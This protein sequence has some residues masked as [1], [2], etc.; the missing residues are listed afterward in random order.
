M[1]LGFVGCF[2]FLFFLIWEKTHGVFTRTEKILY[3][4][5]CEFPE[6]VREA[7]TKVTLC[8]GLVSEGR[9]SEGE[10]GEENG[11]RDR[12]RRKDEGQDLQRRL[13]THQNKR[14]TCFC[15]KPFPFPSSRIRCSWIIGKCQHLR[16]QTGLEHR[17]GKERILR[18]HGWA[19]KPWRSSSNVSTE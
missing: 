9:P 6:K 3:K 1:G 12:Q 17:Q 13:R 19:R 16:G 5:N 11:C 18:S 10:E 14:C 2:C 8:C 7:G 15:V 4:K